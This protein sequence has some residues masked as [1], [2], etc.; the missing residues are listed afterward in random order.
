MERYCITSRL[1]NRY[2]V[3]EPVASKILH[4][5]IAAHMRSHHSLSAPIIA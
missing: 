4:N 1:Y 3:M 2:A 5:K